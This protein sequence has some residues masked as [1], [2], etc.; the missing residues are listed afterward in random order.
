V[1]IPST[2]ARRPPTPPGLARISNRARTLP[3]YFTV[4]L[5]LIDFAAILTNDVDLLAM[6]SPPDNTATII[7]A[8]KQRRK[9]IKSQRPSNA[10]SRSK[11]YHVDE[12]S[13]LNDRHFISH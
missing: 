9:H 12:I 3:Y 7:A 5:A 2:I 13:A 8:G 6:P 1:P 4:S 11:P 10:L